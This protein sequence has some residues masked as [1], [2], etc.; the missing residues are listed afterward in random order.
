MGTF[1][2]QIDLPVEEENYDAQSFSIVAEMDSKQV[3][4]TLSV[5]YNPTSVRLDY[6]RIT[7]EITDN[8]GNPIRSTNTVSYLSGTGMPERSF[9]TYVPDMNRF[10][11]ETEFFVPTGW[12]ITEA[13]VVV[14]YQQENMDEKYTNLILHEDTARQQIHEDDLARTEF[15]V[16]DSEEDLPAAPIDFKVVYRVARVKDTIIPSPDDPEDPDDYTDEYVEE[17]EERITDTIPLVPIIDPSGIIYSGT[18]DNPIAGATVTLYYGGDGQQV[19]EEQLFDM[20]PYN[21]TNPQITDENG[22]YGWN[23]PTGWWKVVAE[24]NGFR[25]ESQWV[26]VLPQHTDL[27]LN[28]NMPSGKSGSY[29]LSAIRPLSINGKIPNGDF[30]AEVTVTNF[31]AREDA[32]LVVATYTAQGQYQSVQYIPVSGLERGVTTTV[33]VDIADADGAVGRMKAFLVS[34]MEDMTPLSAAV[35]Y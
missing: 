13:K 16:W 22:R 2:A 20:T 25:A 5:V 19:G 35:E 14:S 21:Q 27:H 6:L 31:S 1:A 24:K 23:V 7:N 30:E 28:L 17:E 12:I 3:G 18:L 4:E 33:T 34:S 9:Y 15:W 32:L 10:E 8:M 26:H 11:F 29:D